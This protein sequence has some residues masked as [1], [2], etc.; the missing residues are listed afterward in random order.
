VGSL[1]T[2]GFRGSRGN[3]GS[4]RY[5]FAA[6]LERVDAQEA[7]GLE[8]VAP[9]LHST[10]SKPLRRILPANKIE[11]CEQLRTEILPINSKP[12]QIST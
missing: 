2:G 8:P 10:S 9:P 11:S 7:I 6:I 4:T 5:P 12:V 1:P 3:I